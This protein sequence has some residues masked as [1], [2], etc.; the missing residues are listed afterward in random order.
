[1]NI[2]HDNVLIEK[3]FLR[4]L[5]LNFN[6]A[7]LS[8]RFYELDLLRKTI[9]PFSRLRFGHTLFP[10]NSYYK[11]PHLFVVHFTIVLLSAT[12]IVLYSIVSLH[13]FVLRA[14]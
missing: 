10:S 13:L 9:F 11:M 5:F 6:F 3:V 7:L 8:P 1:M 12:L 14:L 4:Y 2:L